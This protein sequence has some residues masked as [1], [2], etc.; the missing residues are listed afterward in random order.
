MARKKRTYSTVTDPAALRDWMEII[1]EQGYCGFD[2]EPTGLDLHQVGIVGLV[3]TTSD[4]EACYPPLTHMTEGEPIALLVAIE[5]VKPRRVFKSGFLRQQLLID[6]LMSWSIR[7]SGCN[8]I[9]D[10]DVGFWGKDIRAA[11][12]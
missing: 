11:I 4:K 1:R 6:F 9:F 12:E 5:I 7:R 3:F 8:S 2:A 10:A